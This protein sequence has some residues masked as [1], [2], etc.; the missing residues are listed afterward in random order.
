MIN[1][2]T[3]CAFIFCGYI[4]YIRLNSAIFTKCDSFRATIL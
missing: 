1:R 3:F 4:R 2:F